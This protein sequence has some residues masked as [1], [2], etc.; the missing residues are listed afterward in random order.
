MYFKGQKFLVAGMSR[1]GESS[2]RFLLARGA[3]VYLYDDIQ[4]GAVRDCEKKLSELGAHV[5]TAQNYEEA[6]RA[7]D[8]LVLSP[9][10]PID[11]A[12]PVAFRR[13]GKAITGEEE[14]AARYL[15]ATSVAVTGTNGKT[16]VTSMI[17]CMLEGCGKNCAACGNIG[18]PTLNFVEKLSYGDFAAIEISS[19]QLETLS[20]LRPHIAVVTNISE[21]HLDRHYNM[22]NYVYLK[23][24]LV[25]GLRESEYAVLNYDDE[26]VRAFA[27]LTRAKVV[28]FSAAQRVDGACCED[29]S[30]VYMGKKLFSVDE[31]PLGGEHNLSNA[32]AC[33]AVGCIL[34]LEPQ[35]ICSALASF[36]GVRHRME[37][38]AQV[39]GVTYINDSKGTNIDAALKAL[40]C[41][42]SPVILLVGGKDKGYDYGRLFSGLSGSP[43]VHAVFYGENRYELLSAALAQGFSEYS[44]CRGLSEAVMLA[45]SYAVPGQCVLLSPASASF[46]EFS[47]Y[48]ERGERFVSIVKS[49][50]EKAGSV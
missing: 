17:R 5:V 16:T 38:V 1:S 33:V 31:L 24:R 36:K 19:F 13:M 25:R 35:S 4:D 48:E 2:A 15:R 30:V 14:L 50:A 21:D 28:Y 7:C 3:E 12:L 39:D 8:V 43:V 23:S 27:S 40:S 20:G 22:E 32:L 9:G 6:L 47:G 42:R 49:F 26:R 45:H 11:N 37:E 34:G 46:D 18:E 10:I 41:M 44:L 29:G